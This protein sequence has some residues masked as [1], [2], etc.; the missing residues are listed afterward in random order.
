MK[1]F[2]KPMKNLVGLL[3][4][5]KLSDKLDNN[6]YLILSY[7]IIFIV[8]LLLWG[9]VIGGFAIFGKIFE[10]IFIKPII[11]IWDFIG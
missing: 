5:K 10:F 11:F 2:R 7:L 1:E 9:I 3:F 4:S 6:F 8:G